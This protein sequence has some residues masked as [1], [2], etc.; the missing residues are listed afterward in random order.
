MSP[1]TQRAMTK[2]AHQHAEQARVT[3]RHVRQKALADVKA[4]GK[5]ISEDLRK[6]HEKEMDKLTKRFVDDVDKILARKEAELKS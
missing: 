4:K 6:Q 3:I 5:G 2:L 1:E